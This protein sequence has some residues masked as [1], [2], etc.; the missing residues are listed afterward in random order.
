MTTT[1]ASD[2]AV[3]RVALLLGPLAALA[4]GIL[5]GQHSAAIGWTTGITV[6]CAVWWI[7]EPIPIAVTGLLPLALFPLVGVLSPDQVGQSLGDPLILLMLGGFM[8]STAM[9]R[10]GVHRRIAIGMVRLVGNGS[11]RRLIWGFMADSVA[12]ISPVR[13][14]Q[15]YPAPVVEPMS[16]R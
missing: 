16:A 6:W 14:S 2:S 12:S 3:Q 5:A 11:D 9:E 4:S 1:D 8:L 13:R 10:S 15:R 7:F